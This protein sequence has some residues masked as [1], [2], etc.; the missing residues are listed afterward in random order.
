[1]SEEYADAFI[2]KGRTEVGDL[3]VMFKRAVTKKRRPWSPVSRLRGTSIRPL[4]AVF[5]PKR[6][7]EPAVTSCV[8]ASCDG[9]QE[10]GPAAASRP[11]CRGPRSKGFSP[12]P[13]NLPFGAL[14]LRRRRFLPTADSRR[15]LA[16][17]GS[18]VPLVLSFSR[19]LPEAQTRSGTPGR[20]TGRNLERDRTDEEQL[21]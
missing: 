5:R 21:S 14:S 7:M 18:Y 8:A 1:M 15:G 20:L 17:S 4:S 16:S 6:R 3:A 2:L 10:C 11:A 9:A 13:T 12:P 19:C